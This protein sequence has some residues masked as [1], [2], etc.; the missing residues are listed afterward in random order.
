M[1]TSNNPLLRDIDKA[2]E[3]LANAIIEQAVDDYRRL[4]RGKRV[5]DRLADNVSIKELKEFFLSQW[6]VN[7]TNV[8]GELIL[9]RLKKEYEDECRDNTTNRK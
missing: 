4:I 8:D 6:F 9:K 1:K 3:N 2:Y 5:F 7:L